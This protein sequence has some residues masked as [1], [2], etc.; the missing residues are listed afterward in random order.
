KT[1]KIG[2]DRCIGIG[3]GAD[4]VQFYHRPIGI[5]Y[6]K[7]NRIGIGRWISPEISAL[8]MLFKG[9]NVEFIFT[10]IPSL[11]GLNFKPG[12]LNYSNLTREP[13]QSLVEFFNET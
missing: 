13:P 9:K 4:G 7:I 5:G 3:I 10:Q 8:Q 2:V 6:L 12:K 11:P 1:C